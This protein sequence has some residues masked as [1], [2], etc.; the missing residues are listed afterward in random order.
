M[1]VKSVLALAFVLAVV[2]AANIPLNNVA[3]AQ[4][5]KN[6]S[7]NSSLSHN[8]IVGSR[9]PGDRLV[10]QQSVVRSSSWM[11]V[12]TWQQ[13]F[14]ATLYTYI[15]QVRSLDQK[16]NGNGAQA[17]LIAGG[18]GYNYVTLRFKSQRG[19]GINHVVQLYAR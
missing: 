4:H 10:R 5:Y 3:F 11:Q 6:N 8:L 17:S 15:T 13:T 16:T 2:A 9:L 7:T 19:H 18:P 12:T 14:N 1:G